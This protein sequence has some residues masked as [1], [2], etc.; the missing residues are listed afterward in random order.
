M[1]GESAAI[2]LLAAHEKA[3]EVLRGDGWSGDHCGRT[4][5][6]FWLRDDGD[7]PGGRDS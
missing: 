2:L 4:R 5:G 7:M 1:K 6:Y 3:K